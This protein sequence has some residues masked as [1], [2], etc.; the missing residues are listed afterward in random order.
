M[1]EWT[2]IPQSDTLLPY[3]LSPYIRSRGR[4]QTTRVSMKKDEFKKMDLTWDLA[5]K[6][7]H[8]K[9]IVW[10]H[11]PYVLFSE[12]MLPNLERPEPRGDAYV[13]K[14]ALVGGDFLVDDE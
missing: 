10:R 7:S 1:P 13:N 3:A 9:E 5:F 14:M 2:Q 11:G 12:F 6:H 8:K 4:P